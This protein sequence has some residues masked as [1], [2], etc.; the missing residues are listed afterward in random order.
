MN[1]T[2][3]ALW[4]IESHLPGDLS[5]D[6]IAAACAVSRFHLSRAFATATGLAPAA[7][8]RARRL[9]EAAKALSG[10]A[11]DILTLA[12]DAGYG[13]H[14]AFTRAFRQQF[15]ATPEQVR[16]RAH[17]EG[18]HL[19]EAIRMHPQKSNRVPLLP[20]RIEKTG[21]MLLF[22]L[23]QRHAGSNAEIPAQWGRFAPYLG[24]IR[25]Q[26]GAATYGVVCNT[27]DSSPGCDYLCGVEVTSFPEHPP[28]FARLRLSPQSYAVFE[29]KGHVSEIDAT[30]AAIWNS[31]LP[32]AGLR[33]VDGPAFERY[34]ERFDG[35][36]G[37]GG[38]EIW[39][40]VADE[41]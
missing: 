24:G 37:M 3:K 5:L 26:A 7:Y 30:W 13:S 21:A 6:E 35:R 41:D 1:I 22:G 40:P 15:G 38:F 23:S 32:E 36:T 31:G 34:D 14:E 8:A 28:E 2:S 25:N 39:I 27:D 19:Q 12:L 20:V 29:H 9:T 11:P 16:E 17:I 4:Y 33:A 18:L 10:G